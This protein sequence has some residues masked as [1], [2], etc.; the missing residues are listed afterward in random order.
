[1]PFPNYSEIIIATAQLMCAAAT[2]APKTKGVN[3]LT[4]F[5][6]LPE[7][8]GPLKGSLSQLAER[9]DDLRV[10]RPYSRDLR[11]LEH[12][13][14]LVVLGSR[15][16]LMDIAGCDACGFSGEPNGCKAAARAGASCSYNSKDLG[17]AVCSAALVAHQRF[18]DNRIIDTAGR[19]IVN[20]KLYREFGTENLFDVA[21][22]ALSISGKNPFFDRAEQSLVG[23]LELLEEEN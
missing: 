21:C 23:S 12:S 2:T 19:A 1:M 16:K 13:E 11:S 5:F 7:S 8:F 3:L 4:A 10:E 6:L 15:R 9:Y 18:V 17:I 14:C 22:V 20:F